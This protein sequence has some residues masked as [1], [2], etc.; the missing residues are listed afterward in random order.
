MYLAS[1]IITLYASVKY[2]FK[3]IAFCK[4]LISQRTAAFHY[5]LEAWSIPDGNGK[6]KEDELREYGI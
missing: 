6:F 1:L 2:Y 5:I 3:G 4:N